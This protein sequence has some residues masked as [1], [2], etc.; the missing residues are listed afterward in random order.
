MRNTLLGLMLCLA[1]LPAAADDLERL[2]ADGGTFLLDWRGEFT[3]ADQRTLKAW[4]LDVGRC[5]GL[6]HGRWPRPEIRIALQPVKSGK[7]YFSDSAVPFARV[8]RNRPEGVLFY[9][10]PGRPLADYVSDWTAYHELSHLF[11][12]YPGRPDV[13]VSE[14]LASYYQNILQ[15]RAGLL[16]A[17]EVRE[18]FR[19]AFERGRADDDD[20]DLTLAELSAAMMERR[21]FMRVYWSGALMFMEADIALRGR[22][23]DGDR[24]TSLDEVLRRY[25]D[26]CLIDGMETTGRQLVADF[27]RVAGGDLF[28]TLYRRYAAT[29]AMPEYGA[30][31]AAAGPVL[32]PQP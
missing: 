22:A 3:P 32:Q 9:V 31:L 5:V 4:L 20:A 27:D 28:A 25:A 19:A 13:W 6:L 8:L 16:T 7:P 24:A 14:G 2:D 1:A 23:A 18:R 10:A 26:C 15:L 29:T 21:A 17:D 11:I 12:P 30:V